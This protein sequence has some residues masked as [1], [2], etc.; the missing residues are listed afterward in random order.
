MAGDDTAIAR[1]ALELSTEAR[2]HRH[3]SGALAR[4]RAV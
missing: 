2:S 4:I 3:K 1:L